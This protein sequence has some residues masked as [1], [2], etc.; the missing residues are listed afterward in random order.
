MQVTLG[1]V[2]HLRSFLQPQGQFSSHFQNGSSSAGFHLVP[3]GARILVR[4]C[5]AFTEG[6]SRP[7]RA[8][9]TVVSSRGPEV[10]LYL[11]H[12]GGK[13]AALTHLASG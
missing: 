9:H 12:S 7:T 1:I 5:H 2:H 3:S 6:P 10:W 4:S 13:G 11:W 8:W